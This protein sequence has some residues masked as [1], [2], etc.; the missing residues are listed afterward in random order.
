MLQVDVL[1]TLYDSYMVLKGSK[2]KKMTV[3]ELAVDHNV[4]QNLQAL[5]P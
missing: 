4:V 5:A 3:C 2:E 1:C